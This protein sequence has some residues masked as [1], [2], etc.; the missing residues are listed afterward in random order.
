LTKPSNDLETDCTIYFVIIIIIT[1]V[2]HWCISLLFNIPLVVFQV[3]SWDLT[4]PL[5]VTFWL[6][7]PPT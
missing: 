2:K 1:A 6:L 5:Y 4:P 7:L 3:M